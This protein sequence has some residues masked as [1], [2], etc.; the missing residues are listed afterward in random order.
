[1]K[2]REIHDFPYGIG[3]EDKKLLSAR[4]IISRHWRRERASTNR[5]RAGARCTV[6][7]ASDAK[8]LS[9][10]LDC[11]PLHANQKRMDNS[12]LDT[13]RIALLAKREELIERLYA[14]RQRLHSKAAP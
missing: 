5:G 3:E 14:H 11:A 10:E 12:S 1:M 13:C 4:R 2:G 8:G 6:E 7:P 9:V